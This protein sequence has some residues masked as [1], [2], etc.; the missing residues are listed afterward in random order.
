PKAT[1]QS[2]AVQSSIEPVQ[3]DVYGPT[4]AGDTLWSVASRAAQTSA[5]VNVFQ[6]MIGLLRQNPDAF[7]DQNVNLLKVDQM[8]QMPTSDAL[9]SISEAEANRAYA[10]QLAAFDQYRLALADGAPPTA[11]QESVATTETVAAAESQAPTEPTAETSETAAATDESA[12]ESEEIL[13]IV[14]ATLEQSED[15]ASA[16]AEGAAGTGTDAAVDTEAQALRD[17]ISTM[18]ETLL[19]RELE[20]QEL[21]ERIKLLEEQVA[22]ASRLMEIESAELAAAQ[23][24]AAAAQQQ[25]E[26]PQPEQVPAAQAPAPDS[27]TEAAP[28]EEVAVTPE[29]AAE[30][31]PLATAQPAATPPTAQKAWWENIL[32]GFMVNRSTWLLIL[33]APLLLLVGLIYFVRRRRSIAEFEESVLTGS[34]LDTPTASTSSSSTTAS[35]EVGTDTSF[36]S[37]FG[38]PGMGT[39]QADEV[40]PLAEAEVYLAYGRDEQAEEVLKEAI[41]RAPTRSELKL[42]LLEIYEQREDLKG[43]ET[44]AEELYP[45]QGEQESEVWTKVIEMG[46]RMNPDNPLFKRVAPVA[47]ATAAT[48]A[49]AAFVTS[50]DES[51]PAAAGSGVEDTIDPGLAPLPT[52]DETSGFDFEPE[53]AEQAGELETPAWPQPEAAE[54]TGELETAAAQQSDHA[55][56]AGSDEAAPRLDDPEA[57]SAEADS[58]DFDLDLGDEGSAPAVD[59]GTLGESAEEGLEYLSST[60]QEGADISAGDSTEAD[61]LDMS[62]DLAREFDLGAEMENFETDT[63][64]TINEFDLSGAEDTI[65]LDDTIDLER[66]SAAPTEE[67]L[68][69]SVEMPGEPIEPVSSIGV[70]AVEPTESL[71]APQWDEA[72]TKLDLAK[73]YIDMGD[74]SGARSIIDEVLREGDEGQRKQAA[75]LASKLAS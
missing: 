66:P 59:T 15:Q 60:A 56:F 18:E 32:D 12:E 50:A 57:I 13:R 21:R 54:Q 55:A 28:S 42:K 51:V 62:M 22:N 52:P 30:S 48:A 70:V 8:L 25:A 4:K 40:D 23:E 45:A 7:I 35:N 6:M 68:A 27:Q 43:F 1:E 47:A 61:G 74:N 67:G 39:M 63:A 64:E 72:A 34:A 71:D 3:G 38:V 75:E 49:T 37:D 14:R 10:E 24:Q 36:L 46:Q 29:P 33:L 53:A 65:E 19:S 16:A 20:N 17:Q 26:T 9:A 44:L 41:S 73:A 11:S 5:D 2:D 31:E 58:L 69:A